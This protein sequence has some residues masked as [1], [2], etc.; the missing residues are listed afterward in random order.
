MPTRL[1]SLVFRLAVY[2]AAIVV[3]SLA[4]AL[5]PPIAPAAL[6]TAADSVGEPETSLIRVLLI[7]LLLAGVLL[8]TMAGRR[9]RWR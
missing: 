8:E 7:G 6:R 4:P 9:A 3:V 2:A 5:D 1:R